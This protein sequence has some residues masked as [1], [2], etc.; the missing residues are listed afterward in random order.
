MRRIRMTV[1]YDGA[2]YS[3][4]QR[5]ENAVSVQQ[6]LEE[7]LHKLLG[8]EVRVTGASRTDAGVHA[9]GQTVHFDTDSRIPPEKY[10]FALN[11]MLPVAFPDP[12]AKSFFP[13]VRYLWKSN[14]EMRTRWSWSDSLKST[15]S[16]LHHFQSTAWHI[17][18]WHLR[19]L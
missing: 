1:E 11:T 19:R 3:G 5:Q 4:W 10:A 2:R 17:R 15:P 6:R 16:T 18:S 7:A 12:T 13:K 8:A 9:L 14:A